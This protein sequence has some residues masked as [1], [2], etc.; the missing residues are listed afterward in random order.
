MQLASTATQRNATNA[1][2][3]STPCK[4]KPMLSFVLRGGWMERLQSEL[5]LGGCS[6][7]ICTSE[8]SLPNNKRALTA[9]SILCA[10]LDAYLTYAEDF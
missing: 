8:P 3:V 10:R 7:E 2:N 4:A 1:E 6:L 5:W 9:Y